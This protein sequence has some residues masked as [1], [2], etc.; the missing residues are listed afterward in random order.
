MS[1]SSSSDPRATLRTSRVSR[2]AG[3]ILGV[4]PAVLAADDAV[5]RLD[6]EVTG[7]EEIRGSIV[8]AVFSSAQ[9]FDERVDP[10]AQARLPLATG[11]V[12]WSTE[13]EAPAIYA[14]IVYQDLNENGEI[15]MRRLGPPREPYGF[16]NNVRRRFGPPGFEEARFLLEPGGLS[17]EIEIE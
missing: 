11:A 3:F 15:D 1:T 10:V 2:F 12:S 4:M 5:A 14:V 9:S 6:V 7:I 8:I 13:L 17:I 16:S